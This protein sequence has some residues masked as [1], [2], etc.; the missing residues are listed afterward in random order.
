[1]AGAAVQLWWDLPMYIGATH[2]RCALGGVFGHEEMVPCLLFLV[3]HCTGVVRTA[4]T[5]QQT[6]QSWAGRQWLWSVQ[7]PSR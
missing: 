4:W 2:L 7:E 5:Y 1:M 6:S 3:A